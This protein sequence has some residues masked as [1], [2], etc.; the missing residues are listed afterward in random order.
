MATTR[1]TADEVDELYQRVPEKA[2]KG[3]Q[4]DF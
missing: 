3:K 2:R 1:Q 4:K